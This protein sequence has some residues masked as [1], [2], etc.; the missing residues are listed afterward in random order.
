MVTNLIRYPVIL[1]SIIVFTS[2]VSNNNEKELTIPRD[3]LSPSEM[4]KILVDMQL[5]EGALIYERSRGRDYRVN[6]DKYFNY[7]FEYHGISR[8]KY[9]KSMAFYKKHLSRLEVIY[10][11]VLSKLNEYKSEIKK[12]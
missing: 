8:A 10:A 9:E 3:V 7:I 5:V 6:R 1:I 4:E 2:C 12:D 11:N